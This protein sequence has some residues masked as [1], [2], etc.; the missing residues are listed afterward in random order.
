MSR[1]ILTNNPEF[2]S[3]SKSSNYI[4]TTKFTLINFLP[5]VIWLQYKQFSNVFFTFI[6]ILNVFFRVYNITT[7]VAPI[8]FIL[9]VAMLRELIEDLA[10]YNQDRIMNRQLFVVIRNGTLMEVRSSDI[11]VGDLISLAI[12]REV[13]CDCLIVSTGRPDAGAYCQTMNLDGETNLKNRSAMVG[14]MNY[15]SQEELMQLQIELELSDPDPRLSYLAGTVLVNGTAYPVTSNEMLLRGC[16]VKHTPNLWGVVCFIGGD[17]K[18]SQ[19]QVIPVTSLSKFTRFLNWLILALFCFM[20]VAVLIL[21]GCALTYQ[22]NLNT[23]WYLYDYKSNYLWWFFRFFI[24]LSMFVPVSLFVSLE[25]V[26]YCQ[27][28]MMEKDPKFFHPGISKERLFRV[29][30]SSVTEEIGYITH[31][32]SDKTGTLT[33]NVLQ[34]KYLFT[35]HKLFNCSAE[36]LSLKVDTNSQIF[37]AIENPPQP[38]YVSPRTITKKVDTAIRQHVR[39]ASAPG[40]I[41]DD[42]P[43]QPAI[44]SD[45]LLTQS[46][47]VL[48]YF[49]ALECIIICNNVMANS[50][51]EQPVVH[52]NDGVATINTSFNEIDYTADSPDEMALLDCAHDNG[53]ILL[54]KTQHS[55]FFVSLYADLTE[56]FVER[57]AKL[58]NTTTPDGYNCSLLE[59]TILGSIAFS[60][61]RKKMSVIIKTSTGA[62]SFIKGAD[63]VLLPLCDIESTL[64]CKANGFLDATSLEGLRTLV[65]ASKSLD[66]ETADK[67][68]QLIQSSL[69]S[70]N[71]EDAANFYNE[72]ANLVECAPLRLSGITAIEDHLQPGVPET[73][74]FFRSAGVKLWVLTGDKLQTAVNI[75]RSA[76]II[77]SSRELVV[78]SSETCTSTEDVKTKLTAVANAVAK[79]DAPYLVVE[80][81]IMTTILDAYREHFCSFAHR[82]PSV[83]VVRAS[84]L[85][86]A[87]VV[88]LLRANGEIVLAVGDGSNDCAMIQSADVGVG[89]AGLEGLQASRTSDFSI[90]TFSQLKRLLVVH[91]RFNY[92]RVAAVVLYSICKNFIFAFQSLLFSIYSAVSAQVIIDSFSTTCYNIFFT[93]LPPVIF[94]IFDKDLPDEACEAFPKAYTS[95]S[96]YRRVNFSAVAQM[97]L[98]A[99]WSSLVIF[100][101]CTSSFYRGSISLGGGSPGLGYLGAMNFTS[102]FL[103]VTLY[104]AMYSCQWNIIFHVG[105]W[106]SVAAF[107]LF[108]LATAL[109]PG[110]TE[111]YASGIWHHTLVQPHFWIT[112]FVASWCAMGPVMVVRYIKR[113]WSPSTSSVIYD[114]VRTRNRVLGIWKKHRGDQLLERIKKIDRS[115]NAAVNV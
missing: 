4:S 67:F 60:S 76:K 41:I 81:G 108:E 53:L 20:V 61:D 19:N 6:A 106:L 78:L 28:R 2:S 17:T 98:V 50:M 88:K 96:R 95:S 63:N 25:V 38:R 68:T 43:K 57:G 77:D 54:N 84:P 72:A 69:S 22:K 45:N 32:C 21:A 18:L 89:I 115:D 94:G 24:I 102:V 97:F 26:R 36:D 31:I 74:S 109:V 107:F 5:K 55:V 75:A 27:A 16:T 40:I 80:G 82:L 3:Q 15:K 44:Q 99:F 104:A 23:A 83:I 56:A 11:R 49:D 66:Q 37:Q 79:D 58:Y 105:L 87:L 9:I 13:P 46:K 112:C 113:I 91:G 64:E 71:E 8:V 42:A 29:K 35:P 30:N 100:F 7:T 34:F 65:L 47:E 73:L 70:I 52:I 1:K 33:E 90:N 92:Y 12:D 93:F 14:T 114:K 39:T 110:S 101:V 59:Y 10:R 62:K 85:H 51:D 111:F 86:K 48:D 103:T